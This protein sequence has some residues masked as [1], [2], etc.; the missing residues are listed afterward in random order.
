MIVKKTL[1]TA[2]VVAISVIC[3]RATLST[4]KETFP[5][6]CTEAVPATN[7]INLEQLKDAPVPEIV[8]F[9]GLDFINHADQ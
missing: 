6:I 9:G 4:A 7:W 3:C 1:F 8:E 5:V 2:V